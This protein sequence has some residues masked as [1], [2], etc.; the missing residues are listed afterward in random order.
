LLLL[1]TV[2]QARAPGQLFT[3]GI[4]VVNADIQPSLELASEGITRYVWRT[5]FG[6]ILIEVFANGE[7]AVNGERLA[8][9]QSV[10]PV[11]LGR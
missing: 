5:Q 3:K 1:S 6:E 8:I 11:D 7:F 9:S 10:K 2:D 4:P